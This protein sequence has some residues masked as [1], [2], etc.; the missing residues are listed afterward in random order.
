MIILSVSSPFRMLASVWASGGTFNID[1]AFCVRIGFCKRC[2]RGQQPR[3]HPPPCRSRLACGCPPGQN[4]LLGRREAAGRAALAATRGC[5]GSFCGPCARSPGSVGQLR[6]FPA[7]GFRAS[8][9]GRAS[10]LV[11]WLCRCAGHTDSYGDRHAGAGG[12][13]S[14]LSRAAWHREGSRHQ[15]DGCAQPGPVSGG[16]RGA[17][18]H[19]AGSAGRWGTCGLLEVRAGVQRAFLMRVRVSMNLM[20]PGQEGPPE[21]GGGHIAKVSCSD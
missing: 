16:Q 6:M 11:T 7:L 15:C 2:L 3:T 17:G 14:H 10:L 12:R 18:R 9:A 5:P 20:S 13:W 8:N 19:P 4:G 21:K 1:T